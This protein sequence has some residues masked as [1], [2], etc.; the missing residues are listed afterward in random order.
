MA[1]L[2]TIQ[3]LYQDTCSLAI[4]ETH[5]SIDPRAPFVPKDAQALA[6]QAMQV[7]DAAKSLRTRA[8]AGLAKAKV[9]DAASAVLTALALFDYINNTNRKPP[10]KRDVLGAV[11]NALDALGAI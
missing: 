5:M 2:K 8:P 11:S 7:A 4:K 9:D 6:D 3:A 10:I 1:N